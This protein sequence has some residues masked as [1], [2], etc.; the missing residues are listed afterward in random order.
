MHKENKLDLNPTPYCVDIKL[1][2]QFKA[3]ASYTY[4]HSFNTYTQSKGQMFV[5]AFKDRHVKTSGT[6]IKHSP[7]NTNSCLFGV[8]WLS[9]L[10]WTDN[11]PD[12]MYKVRVS[13]AMHH[14]QYWR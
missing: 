10:V 9:D 11:N 2:Y 14:A 4:S 12:S 7:S 3:R 1:R 8:P 13:M 6:R 5:F